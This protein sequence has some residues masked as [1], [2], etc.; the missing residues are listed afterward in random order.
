MLESESRGEPRV[1][2][3]HV[4]VDVRIRDLLTRRGV[5][6]P[7]VA[8]I[9][10]PIV[11]PSSRPRRREMSPGSATSGRNRGSPR[12]IRTLKRLSLFTLIFVV[13]SGAGVWVVW[14]Q[15]AGRSVEFDRG[16]LAAPVVAGCVL[17]LVVYFVTD[18]LRLHYTLRA[19]GLRLPFRSILRLVFINIFVSNVT[20]LATGGGVAQV[21]YLRSRGVAL[22]TATAATTIRT[23]LAV[24]FIFS[25]APV[26][27]LTVVS[28]PGEVSVGRV[29][30]YLLPSVAAYVGFFAVVLLRTRWLALPLVAAVRALGALRILDDERERRWRFR[31]R[32][33]LVRFADGFRHYLEGS[34]RDV[35]L[36]VLFTF[37]FLLSLFS[38]PAILL[39]GL[40]Y[41]IPYG[42]VVGLMVL[43]TF[44]SYFSPTPGASGVA[45]GTFGFLF[46]GLVSAD[47]LVQL[48]LA[49]RALSIYI[50]MAVGIVVT[51]HELTGGTAPDV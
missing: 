42:T 38:F 41:E 32:R 23:V 11:S 39:A 16:L 37:V 43:T 45:E 29:G 2:P 17:F 30:M 7:V 36:S 12:L 18:G 47:D 13:L 50:G 3:T 21:F 10:Q 28:S 19:L 15:M 26:F 5:E 8:R 31:A 27:F 1:P 33:E 46:A 25:S 14:S 20:P 40:G 34:R 6:P 44:V 49:W 48:T 22:G 9:H 24:L 51:Q 4:G 35:A